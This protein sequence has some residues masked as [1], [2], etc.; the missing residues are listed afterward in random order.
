MHMCCMSVLEYLDLEVM[1]SSCIQSKTVPL[2]QYIHSGLLPLEAPVMIAESVN[3]SF[4]SS[5]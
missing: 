1:F 5:A 3:F 2:A 4:L